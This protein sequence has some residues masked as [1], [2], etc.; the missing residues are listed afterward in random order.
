VQ[1]PVFIPPGIGEIIVHAVVDGW[2]HKFYE[3]SIR[4]IFRGVNVKIEGT[5][6]S[7]NNGHLAGI[8]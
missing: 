6:L 7:E 4:D 5:G 2:T 8:I 1:G 3:G